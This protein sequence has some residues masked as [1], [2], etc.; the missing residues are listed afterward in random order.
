MSNR[1]NRKTFPGRL[2]LINETSEPIVPITPTE[3]IVRIVRISER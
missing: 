3:A 1:Q 2:H